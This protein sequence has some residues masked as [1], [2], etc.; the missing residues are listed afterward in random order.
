MSPFPNLALAGIELTALALVLLASVQNG[1]HVVQLVLAARAL[2]DDPP[3]PRSELVW[4][5]TSEE[6]PSIS[7]LAPAYNEAE[8]IVES[9]RSLLLQQYPSF[10]VVVINDGSTDGTL[11]VLRDAFGLEQVRRDSAAT[12]SHTPVRGLFTSRLQPA[13]LV[14]DKE[15]GGKADALNAGLNYTKNAVFCSMDADSIL[16][17]DALLRAVQPFIA[18]PERV[19]AAGGTVRIANGCLVAGGR[20]KRYRLPRDPLALLQTVEYMRAFLMA[21]LAWSRVGTLTIISGAFGLFRRSAVIKAGGY[22]RGLV[23]EYMELVLRL[24]RLQREQKREYKI[25]FVPEPVCW[26]EAPE[27]LKSLSRQR[28]RW[29]RGSLEA[30]ALHRT[31]LFNPRYGRIG[32][33]GLGGVLVVDVLGPVA[34]ILGYLL[35]PTFCLLGVLSVEF[36]LAFLAVSIVFGIAVSVG[37]LVLE[38][39]QLRRAS[40][41]RDLLVL[42]AWAVVE[43]LG[44]RQLNSVWRLM[45]C[46]DW[47]RGGRGWGEMQRKG[48]ARA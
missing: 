46:W 45:G 14:I 21:R 24:H 47:L 48:F 41:S 44:Y 12:L 3:Q 8:T 32:F 16:E 30:F 35:M 11:E 10:E 27:T 17:P 9:V 7:I 15:N 31:M 36:L 1:L 19:I 37:A 2:R 38:E 26:T 29:Q 33:A 5:R 34:E 20:V 42:A 39:Q 25:A 4:Q 28:R 22:A 18:D 40:Q 13:L 43:N 6:A 23:G